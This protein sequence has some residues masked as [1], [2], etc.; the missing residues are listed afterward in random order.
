MEKASRLSI[1]GEQLSR[2]GRFEEAVATFREAVRIDPNHVDSY[3][4]LGYALYRLERYYESVEAS[5]DAI[6]L[7]K[8]FEPYY[9]SGLAYMEL[10]RWDKARMA[11]E[12]ATE[13]INIYSWEER[14]TLAYYHLGRSTTRLGE[15]GQMIVSVED[16]LKYNPKGTL[17][18]LQLGSLYL[19]VG[20]REAARAQYRILKDSDPVLAEELLKLIEKHGKPA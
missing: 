3:E 8:G 19:W 11:F 12:S 18:R 16:I 9:N 15:A 6:K 1:G 20:K 5:E 7:R 14:Y 17:K 10:K 13:H 2:E 4:R